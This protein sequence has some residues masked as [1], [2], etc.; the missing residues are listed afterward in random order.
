MAGKGGKD[1]TLKMED[2]AGSSTYTTIGGLRSATM[3]RE[4]AEIESTNHGSNQNKEVLDGAGI[5]SMSVS[6]EG[7]FTDDANL[8]D[9][10][11]IAVNQTLYSFQIVDADSGRT[12]TANFKITTFER[13]GE[14]NAEQTY[15]VSLVSSGAVTIS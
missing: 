11:D 9:L 6:G 10:E 4:F 14:Y 13:A 2:S 8:G 12:Y 3:S 7:I 1:F 15:S 5:R